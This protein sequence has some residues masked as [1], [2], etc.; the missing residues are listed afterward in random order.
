[1]TSSYFTFRDKDND[2]DLTIQESSESS[3]AAW[4][5][6]EECGVYLPKHEAPKAA[7][8]LLRA[9]GWG[10]TTLDTTMSQDQMALRNSM[11][12]A[13]DYL[14]SVVDKQEKAAKAAAFEAAIYD[15]AKQLYNVMANILAISGRIG[16]RPEPWEQIGSENQEIWVKVARH[17]RILNN[18]TKP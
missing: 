9:A 4:V 5:D 16:T 15:E 6:V 10:N 13:L 18:R 3:D 11:K 8:S 1:M 12:G 7:A 17:A 2:N 14:D